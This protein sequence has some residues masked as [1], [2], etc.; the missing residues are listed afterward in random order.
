MHGRAV[1]FVIM[2]FGRKTDLAGRSID[3]DAIYSKVMAPAVA[4]A[5]LAVV[6][7]DEEKG[8]G[9]IHKMMYE[10]ILLSEF[11][12]ADLTISNANVYYE[13]GIR[14]AAR[15]STTLLTMAQGG[16]AP[17]DVGPLRSFLYQIDADGLPCDPPQASSALAR[18]IADCREQ[19]GVDSPL[20]QLLE[21]YAAAPIDR[22]KTDVFREKIAYSEGLKTRLAA[23]RHEGAAAL[24]RIRDELGDLGATEA[25]VVIDLMLSYRAINEWGRVVELYTHMDKALAR[26]VL[27]R[28]QY[29]MAL[30]RMGRDREAES[31]LDA[32][33]AERGPTSEA[34]GLLGRIHK[35][36]WDRSRKGNP[37]M[38]RGHLRRAI[39]AYRRGFEM[40][41]RDAFPGV[42]A[43]TLMTIADPDDPEAKELANVVRYSVRRRLTGAPDYWDRAT[44][45]E[46]AVIAD[47]PDD[48]EDAFAD[49]L[50][51]LD[52]PWKA[53][54]TARNL[55][56]IADAREKR[57]LNVERL[58]EIVAELRKHA[59]PDPA[60]QIS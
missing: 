7:A 33:I 18:A 5:G 8:A 50:A 49:A 2:P 22:L 36:R 28:E 25:G 9:F 47:D 17:F 31:V 30:N 48:A 34:C 37:A 23:A 38:A 10:R 6:R 20:F 57:G 13:L 46:L 53:A 59:P 19:R 21:G 43:V 44:L 55:S 27:A 32:L 14:H 29:A 24:D 51:A 39:A 1:C 12:V 11:A 52:E 54:T 60:D 58:R 3:F 35:D 56:L 40:D 4:A 41:W 26:T 15:P 42:N 16:A 45:L